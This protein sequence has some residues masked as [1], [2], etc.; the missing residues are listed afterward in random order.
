MAVIRHLRWG[1]G[2]SLGLGVSDSQPSSLSVLALD[3]FIFVL[4]VLYLLFSLPQ[5]PNT[6]D[7]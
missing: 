3:S 4:Y 1:E 5:P 7:S 6:A 2:E